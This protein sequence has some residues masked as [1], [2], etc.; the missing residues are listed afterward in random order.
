VRARLFDVKR[1][2]SSAGEVRV[3]IVVPRYGLTAVRRNRL[4]RRVRE[5]V[6]LQLLPTRASTDLLIRARRQAYDAPMN[7]LRDDLATV[8]AQ[9]DGATRPA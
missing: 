4:K 8:A 5:I 6:R 9:L 7:A 1:I 3:A 2:D